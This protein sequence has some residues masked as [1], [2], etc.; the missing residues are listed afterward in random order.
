MR[1]VLDANVVV[2]ALIRPDGW[3]ARE[4]RRDDVAWLAPWSIMDE[5][6]EHA[7]EYAEKAG[8]TRREWD[9]RLRTLLRRIEVVPAAALDPAMA[10]PLVE[11]AEAIDPDDA[12]YLATVVAT[13]ADH[14]WTR[15][16]ALLDAFPGIARLVLPRP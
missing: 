16:A 2:A 1:V 8:C 10:S 3:T 15:D 5:V 11:Q 13:N 7:E 4:L 12:A 14:L 6:G 9:R